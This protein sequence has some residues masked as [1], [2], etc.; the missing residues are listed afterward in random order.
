MSFSDR[1]PASAIAISSS[2][3]SIVITD[4]TPSDPC[5]ASP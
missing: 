4:A 3:L 2:V 1:R 5:A